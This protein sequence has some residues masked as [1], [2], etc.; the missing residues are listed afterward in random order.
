[1]KI[2]TVWMAK[3]LRGLGLPSPHLVQHT[4]HVNISFTTP[5][6]TKIGVTYYVFFIISYNFFDIGIFTTPQGFL[7]GLF[8]F[9]LP[10]LNLI[11]ILSTSP[12]PLWFFVS[13]SFTWLLSLRWI[14]TIF[15]A[16]E[17]RLGPC[18]F[19]H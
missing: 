6:N 10:K 7:S 19:V 9:T 12:F 17:A 11:F 18:V 3:P 8:L 2:P 1:M 16:R 4:C 5:M 13:F 15:P 14:F